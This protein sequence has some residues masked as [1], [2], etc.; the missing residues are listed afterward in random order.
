MNTIQI[1]KLG[2]DARIPTKNWGDAGYDLYS[3]EDYIL[4]PL[5]R[6]LLKTNIAISIPNGFFGRICDRSGNALKKGLH[7]MAGIIDSTYRGEVGVVLIN[8]NHNFRNYPAYMQVIDEKTHKQ[9]FQHIVGEDVEIKKGD[10]IAQLIIEE[11]KEISW[12]EV[13]ELDQTIRNVG[14]FGSTGR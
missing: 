12:Q 6:K 10:R 4:K 9:V 1:K 3:T 8:L 7:V 11:Y 5:E 2:K 13:T 14:G